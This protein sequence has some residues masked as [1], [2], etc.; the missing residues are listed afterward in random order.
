VDEAKKAGLPVAA[1]GDEG[2][3]ECVRAGVLSIEHG[4]FVSDQTLCM[5]KEK[6]TYLV[7]TL[8]QWIVALKNDL[9]HPDPKGDPVFVQRH[10]LFAPQTRQVSLK[11]FKMGIP[12][13]GGTD[14][15]YDSPPG[16]GIYVTDDAA[17]CR[18]RDTQYGCPQ[19]IT[20]T[21]ANVWCRSTYGSVKQGY[22][23]DWSLS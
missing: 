4:S 19:A 9:E 17:L 11:A 1:H 20:S 10:K 12:V 23:A 18:N 13:I 21:S 8:A 3:S 14:Q 2:G 22:D 16:M 15:E 6:G 5:M 7:P